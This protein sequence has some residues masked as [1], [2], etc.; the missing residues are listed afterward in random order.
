MGMNR[1]WF[2]P[3]FVKH[4]CVL[5]L[6]SASPTPWSPELKINEVPRAPSGRPVVTT[7]DWTAR[8]LERTKLSETR[9]YA[10]R[11]V[12]RYCTDN[13]LISRRWMEERKVSPVCSLS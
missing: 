13:A 11:K 1:V 3:S 9:T 6:G 4:D 2:L 12:C 7:C 8:G 10:T 5:G